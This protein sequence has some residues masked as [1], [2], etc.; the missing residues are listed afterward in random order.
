MSA[1]PET[2]YARCPDGGFVAYQAIG[3]GP[4]DLLVV[5][6][7]EPL[8]VD[9]LRDEPRLVHCQDRLSG[10]SRHIW[11]DWRGRGASDAVDLPAD[12]DVVLGQ[13][14]IMAVLD[15]AGSTSTA[16]FGTGS[17]ACR[18]MLFAA[19][20]PERVRALVLMHP[21]ARFLADQDYEGL[22]PEQFNLFMDRLVGRWGTLDFDSATNPS[23]AEDPGARRWIAKAQ[24][25][26][27]G[28]QDF[29]RRLRYTYSVDVRPVLEAVRVP[30]LVIRRTGAELFSAQ[31]R[32]V[33]DHVPGASAV[34]VPGEDLYFFLGDVD[35]LFDE[36]EAFVTGVRPDHDSDRVLAT[37]LFTD[38]VGSTRRASELGD[39]RWRDLLAVHDRLTQDEVARHR[40]SRV[41][42]T[43]D[44]VLATFT[45]PGRA[46]RCA[47]SIRDAL[48]SVG[49]EIRAG[50]H[51][52]E[53]ELR[54]E[55]VAGLGVH[56]TQRVEALAQPGE[57]LVTRTVVDLVS[58]SGIEF[59]DGADH[60]LKGV[61]GSWR[62]HS[63]RDDG[64]AAASSA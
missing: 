54:G 3:Q 37:I 38:I 45:G 25:L 33:A 35:Q 59:S 26:S 18:A 13:D 20:H 53:I 19:S 56:I 51:T 8:V 42:W 34:E 7:T 39:R 9:L 47:C 61:S 12:P 62:L 15:A 14:E 23:L 41:K 21:F 2:A 36:I 22:P 24:R 40:G 1:E 32:Y 16:L 50:I 4:V 46:I 6:G 27:F 55:D 64:G 49:L 30:T 28:P 10:F 43:G 5:G 31:A 58:G 17:G 48:S 63:V 52:G 29:S 57:V 11:F 60:E 44:G